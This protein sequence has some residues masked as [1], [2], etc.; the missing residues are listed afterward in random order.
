MLPARGALKGV[1]SWLRTVDRLDDNDRKSWSIV[2]NKRMP[3]LLRQLH[4]A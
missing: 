2:K 1:I 4:L 3:R